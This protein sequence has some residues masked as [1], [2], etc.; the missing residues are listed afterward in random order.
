MEGASTR[1]LIHAGRLV[2]AG[3]GLEEASQANRS[4]DHRR[5]GYARSADG[6]DRGV[7]LEHDPE[8]RKPVFRK[9]HAQTKC[10]NLLERQTP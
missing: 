6:C 8:K 7:P 1:M 2:A 5:F 9:D 3:V 4:A 10:F